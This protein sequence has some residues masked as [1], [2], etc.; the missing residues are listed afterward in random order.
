MKV[1]MVYDPIYLK[2]DTGEHV[3]NPGRLSV[4]ISRLEGVGLRERLEPL[5]P[6]AAI[7][8]ELALVHE[9]KYIKYIKEM[10]A[11]GGGWLDADTVMS[12]DSYQAAVY[13][14]GGIMK[15][16]EAVMEGQLASAFALV[17]PPGHHATAKR[18][19]GFCLFNN[20]A[21]AARH[22][23]KQ[24]AA[25]SVAIIDF[26]VHHGNGTQ[27]AFYNDRSVLYIS[28]HQAPHYPGTG[29]IQETGSRMAEGTTLNIPLPAGSGDTEY[30]RVFKEIVM[31]ATRSFEPQLILVSAGYDGHWADRMS[32]MQ[33]SVEGYAQMM[34][35]IKELADELC[36]GRLVLGLEGGYDPPALA[37]S[38]EATFKVLLGESPGADPLGKLGRQ[39]GVPDIEDLVRVVKKL[40]R[41]G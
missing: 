3:E 1:G 15:A 2:H 26:D 30:L 32:M 14:A 13:A 40:H 39:Y 6:R 34:V 27:E 41:L 18:A 10:A 16:T 31:P 7:G 33:L 8:G 11:K 17:R 29:D 37:A 5:E 25:E 9:W 28:T 20:I 23:R 4:I 21:I 36:G 22:A 35:F 19:M 24:L 38:V 12:A